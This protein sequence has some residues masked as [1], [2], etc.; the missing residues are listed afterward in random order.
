MLKSDKKIN[1][2]A[3]TAI[4]MA[5]ATASLEA[6]A[7]GL[8]KIA[9]YSLLGQPLKAEIEV[10]ANN[11]ELSSLQ[12]KL[13]SIDVYRQADIEYNA[14]L[15]SLK[16][17]RELVERNGR[18]YVQV[19]TDKPVNEPFI[20]MLVELG[21]ASGRLVREY[22][23]LLD[24][25]GSTSSATTAPTAPVSPPVVSLEEGALQSDKNLQVGNK[26]SAVIHQ[27]S[28]APAAKVQ[29]T[30]EVSD[31]PITSANVKNHKVRAGDTLGKIASKARPDGVSL[32][33]M[34][35]ALLRTN[36]AAFDDGNMNRLKVGKILAIPEIEVIQQI[37][38]D[39]ARK[40][41]V[42]QAANFDA[43]RQRL[44]SA[45][46]AKTEARDSGQQ[47][48]S[49][50]IT[51]KVEESVPAPNNKDKLEIS[52][53]ENAKGS[54][55]DAKGV[56]A[57]D[58]LAREKALKEAQNRT[59]ELEKNL[60]KMKQLDELQNKTGALDAQQKAQVGASAKDIANPATPSAAEIPVSP[61]APKA[62]A[63]EA[64]K[65]EV[66]KAKVLPLEPE[67]EPG[68]LEE[69]GTL[70]LG[71][72]GILALL[73][74]WLGYS[75]WK[76]KKESDELGELGGVGAASEF[77]VQSTFG[78]SID[79][80]ISP[81]S[82]TAGDHG[83]SQFGI[84]ASGAVEPS[85]DALSQADTFLAF[86]RTA[87]AEEVLISALEAQP[88]R[89]ELYLK[90]LGIYAEQDK[91]DEYES[92]AKRF[93]EKTPENGADW[94]TARVMGAA[95]DP[96]NVLYQLSSAEDMPSEVA[97]DADVGA[98]AEVVAVAAQPVSEAPEALVASASADQDIQQIDTENLDFDLDFDLD[99]ATPPASSNTDSAAPVAAVL[100]TPAEEVPVLDFDFD[101]NLPEA[102]STAAL[103][104]VA[105]SAPLEIPPA[106]KA[107]NSIDFDFDLPLADTPP[108]SASVSD[109]KLDA[110]D[111]DLAADSSAPTLG[112]SGNNDADNA[113]VATKLELAA[114]YEEMGDN[115]GARELYQ[116]A[117]AEGSE[118]QQEF[119]RAKLASLA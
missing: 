29:A 106:E 57:A 75:S 111:L 4:A 97:T 77:S 42:A 28:Q 31:K 55:G 90:L 18:R 20:N 79:P 6:H 114:A 9:V 2:L 69:N 108:V 67:P 26:P 45:A 51:P 94:E 46:S 110:L 30:A 105:T 22:T 112:V 37:T 104:E 85:V 44:A 27:S 13:A 72:G 116:E 73:L 34:L 19:T 65:A 119:A 41:V 3:V 95:I 66:K 32:D 98:P 35:V 53:S 12:A 103:G 89:S 39:E 115:S 76:K 113:E 8:G 107:D 48:V 7:A 70:V 83:A 47:V 61:P 118:T 17:S 84:S 58:A 96:Q 16:F 40:E 14:V 86:G 25:P 74:G 24:P 49:G 117:L 87:Q 88:D 81:A 21:W 62:K 15:S 63:A 56:A 80:T 91:P 100:A 71:G 36:Q 59:A 78:P 23:F 5:M 92:L 43:Y 102:S 33:Q 50:K 64:A 109:L 38:T 68:F 60:S 54:A 52:K 93:R 10:S 82:I 1:L 11:D 99:D 101:L